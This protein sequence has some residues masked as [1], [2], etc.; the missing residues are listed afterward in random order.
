MNAA[1]EQACRIAAEICRLS[2][3]KASSSLLPLQEK[4]AAVL[5]D[6]AL[7]ALLLPARADEAPQQQ[8]DS[9]RVLQS[10]ADLYVST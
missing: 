4:L 6:G 9:L 1:V 8:L 10:A 7:P 3:D 5:R 2:G